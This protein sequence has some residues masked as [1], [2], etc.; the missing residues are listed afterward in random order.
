MICNRGILVLGLLAAVASAAVGGC[1]KPKRMAALPE[2]PPEIAVLKFGEAEGGWPPLPIGAQNVTLVSWSEVSV[3]LTEPLGVQLQ[4]AALADAQVRQ[5][6]GERF[7]FISTDELELGKTGR[8]QTMAELATR[9]TFFSHTNNVAVEVRMLGSQVKNVKRREGYQP[10]EGAEE[11]DLAVQLARRDSRIR[12]K[13]VGL[14]AGALVAF[15]Q[16]DQAGYGNR[17]LYV[18]FSKSGEGLANYMALVDLTTQKVLAAGPA[19][20]P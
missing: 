5:L 11:I 3:S 1:Q 19:A 10:P 14:E 16:K 4:Q 2:K 9:L 20:G 15:P 13:V 18:N 7:V 12:E 6:L 17:V 8:P